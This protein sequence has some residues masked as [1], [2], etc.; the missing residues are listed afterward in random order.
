MKKLGV[1]SQKEEMCYVISKKEELISQKEEFR[2]FISKKQA[3]PKLFSRS[4]KHQ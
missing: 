2:C 3:T 1:I 4:K